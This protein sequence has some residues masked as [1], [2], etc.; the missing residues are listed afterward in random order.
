MTAT[1]ENTM[2]K[3]N[4]E[5]VPMGEPFTFAPSHRLPSSYC[6]SSLCA[7]FTLILL[8]MVLP[9]I[10]TEEID[11]RNDIAGHQCR[12][13]LN[14]GSWNNNLTSFDGIFKKHTKK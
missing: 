13:F 7:N 10:V 1:V 14:Q 11:G 6:Q 8:L 2:A 3:K 12:I 9:I 4:Y 5:S